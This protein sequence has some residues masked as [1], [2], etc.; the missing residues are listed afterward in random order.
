[1]TRKRLIHLAAPDVDDEDVRRVYEVLASRYLA[2]GPVAEELERAMAERVGARF[3][4]AV[5]SG[6]AALHL[7]I[8]AA[9][10]REG[11]LVITSPFSFV[12]SANAILYE[13]GIP[14][15]AD[16]D[17]ETLTL[18]PQ[19]TL[20]AIDAIVHRRSGW[21][22]LLPRTCIPTSG[23]LRAVLPVHI[24]GRPAEIRGIVEA[25][26]NA[27]IAIIEDACEAL[28]AEAD[29]VLAGRWGDA[30]TFGFAPN[31]P[32]TSGEGG[33]VVTDNEAWARLFRSLRNQGR[34][35]DADRPRCDRLGFNYRMD[36][37]SAA[38]GVAQLRRLDE[39]L[40]RR[41][42][43]AQR[44]SAFFREVDGVSPLA[45]ARPGMTVS[46]VLYAIR[47]APDIDRDRLRQR[48]FERGVMTQAYFWPIHLQP[49]YIERFGYAPGD[50]TAAEAAGHSMLSLPFGPNL[51]DDDMDFVCNAVA[52]E[53]AA[54]RASARLMA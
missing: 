17:P 40:R 48:L 15:F 34:S 6:T 44:Y 20:E 35:A 26:R 52:E 4:V 31:K 9:E 3:A 50:F 14:V 16:V 38:L 42:A 19:K 2:A 11:D 30:A 41:E 21:R 46:P 39:L 7:A 18:D 33:M 5:S 22:H 27:G 23:T 12:A 10:V 29:G 43:V 24:F 53:V 1:M 54:L 13:R 25:S 28:G 51:P 37:M 32:I 45:P 8:I 49:F 47:L 36:E